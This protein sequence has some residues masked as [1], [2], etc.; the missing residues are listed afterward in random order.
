MWTTVNDF[1]I[2]K[3]R[4]PVVLITVDG[5]RFS[6][7]LFVQASARTRLGYESAPD[8]LN[9]DEPFFPLATLDGETI[10]IAKRQVRELIVAREDVDEPEWEIGTAAELDIHLL[11]GTTHAGTV[12]IQQESARSRALDFLNRFNDRFLAVYSDSGVVLVNCSQIAWVA[13]RHD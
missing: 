7:D 10:L 3:S 13:Q 9:A 5:Q 2:E 12:L 6:G 1:R 8:V 11:G 4:L